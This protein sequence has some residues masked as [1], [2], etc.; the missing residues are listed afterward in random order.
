ML[1][2]GATAKVNARDKNGSSLIAWFVQ[3]K[4]RIH[5]A[6]FIKTPFEEKKLSESSTFNTLKKLFR[7]NSICIYIDAVYRTDDTV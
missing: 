2:G 3:F 7:N 4:I 6:F 5:I 1:T